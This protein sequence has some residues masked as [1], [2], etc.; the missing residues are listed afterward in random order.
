MHV[1][2]SS[3]LLALEDL[4]AAL[5]GHGQVHYSEPTESDA[6]ST[7]NQKLV[8]CYQRPN[9]DLDDVV[10]GIIEFAANHSELCYLG[11]SS[12]RTDSM[13]LH[14]G[15][16][17]MLKDAVLAQNRVDL[18]EVVA[19]QEAEG[20]AEHLATWGQDSC[21]VERSS[22]AFD[23]SSAVHALEAHCGMFVRC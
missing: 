7:P 8:Q 14:S 4:L 13:V 12:S 11:Y 2:H 16:R 15:C 18:Q 5:G 17:I 9:K 10:R 3:S 22:L 19:C 20:V 1:Q 23:G 21:S 6:Y